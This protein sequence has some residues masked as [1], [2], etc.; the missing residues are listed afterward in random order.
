[1]GI[2]DPRLLK[3]WAVTVELYCIRNELG[4]TVEREKEREAE[5]NKAA[6]SVFQHV[7]EN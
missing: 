2:Q 5:K 7:S 6:C 4:E 1:M 3:K